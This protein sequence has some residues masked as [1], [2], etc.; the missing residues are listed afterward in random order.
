MNM[1]MKKNSNVSSSATNGLSA[2]E[3]TIQLNK[4]N[5]E[6][7]RI[8]QALCARGVIWNHVADAL[9]EEELIEQLWFEEQWDLP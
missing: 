6:V 4:L 8:C 1:N 3:K 7:A 9:E 2:R 5:Q